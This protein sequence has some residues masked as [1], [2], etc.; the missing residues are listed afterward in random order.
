MGKI[1]VDPTEFFDIIIILLYDL[2]KNKDTSVIKNDD[3][4]NML[5]VFK[6]KGLYTHFMRYYLQHNTQRILYRRIKNIFFKSDIEDSIIRI[7][8]QFLDNVDENK[9]SDEFYN[10]KDSVRK[11]MTEMK[12]VKKNNPNKIITEEK[13]DKII[14]KILEEK[15]II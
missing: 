11:C 4:N 14:T 3:A 9:K 12:N 10:I 5:E 7:F 6:K 1:V 13:L 15:G 8:P 2:L